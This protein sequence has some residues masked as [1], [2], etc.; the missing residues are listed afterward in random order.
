MKTD[1]KGNPRMNSRTTPRARWRTRA[2]AVTGAL[3]LGVSMMAATSAVAD[4]APADPREGLSSGLYD[5]GTASSNVEHLATLPKLAGLGTNSDLAFKDDMAIVGN[6]NGVQFYDVADPA[7]PELLTQFICPGSQNDASVVGDLLFLSVE[8]TSARLDCTTNPQSTVFRGV[9]VF[10]ISDIYNPV[11][12]AAVQTCRGSHTHTVLQDPDDTENIYIYVSGTAGVRAASQLAGCSNGAAD[13][14]NPSR[15]RIEVIKVPVADPAAAAVV[16]ES[17]LFADP[18][19]GAVNGLQ[20]GPTAPRHPSGGGWSPSPNTNQC[21]DI[22]VYAEIGLAAGACA[23]NGI[24][25]DISDPAN[26]QRI[27]AV[28]DGNFAYWHSA[29]FNND[30]TTVVFT[31]EWGGGGG[32]YCQSIHRPEWGANAIYDIVDGKMEFRSYYKIPN[33]QTNR[34]NCVAHNGSLVPVPGRDIMVQAW[35]QGGLSVF[36]FTDSA[37]PVEIGYFDRGPI[38]ATSA[39]SGGFWSTYWYNGNIYGSELTRG[40]DTFQLTPSAHL[41]ANEIAAASEFA[42]PQVNVQG[43]ESFSHDASY[44]V[45]KSFVDQ[46][47]RAGTLSGEALA[48]VR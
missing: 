29:T 32:A 5:A 27:D 14:E 2:L 8:A 47:E 17:R 39:A 36:D 15:W 22:T 9:R 35:Y 30:G 45:A 28:A 23:G 24:L 10:D 4:P 16:T 1:T 21:H 41:S 13:T 20:N 33:V 12:V 46:A 44:N 19:T 42:S 38:S 18:V 3:T 34:E 37:N 43:Q 25:I 40:F 26:P 11:Q 48:T 7:N 31:D 6:Y